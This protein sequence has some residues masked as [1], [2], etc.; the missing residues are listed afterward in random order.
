MGRHGH[1]ISG[2]SQ[3]GRLA[4]GTAARIM[5]DIESSR[6]AGRIPGAFFLT[7]MRPDLSVQDGAVEANRAIEHVLTYPSENFFLTF[8]YPAALEELVPSGQRRGAACLNRAAK[9]IEWG[10]LPER[11]TGQS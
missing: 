6:A 3:S 2:R 7:K 1:A 11:W 4:R 5:W 8:R 10:V 9:R